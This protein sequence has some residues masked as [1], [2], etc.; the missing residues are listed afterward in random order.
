[1]YVVFLVVGGELLD[2]N[3]SF[4]LNAEKFSVCILVQNLTSLPTSCVQ[5]AC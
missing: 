4:Y 3:E 5:V 1:M 2:V